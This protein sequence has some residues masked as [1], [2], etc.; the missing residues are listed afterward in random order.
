MH[1]Y[2]G[3]WILCDYYSS[4]FAVQMFRL[5]TLQG[6]KYDGALSGYGRWGGVRPR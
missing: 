1:C 4:I 6:A 3:L 5:S 2:R